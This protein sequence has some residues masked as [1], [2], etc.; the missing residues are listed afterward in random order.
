MD[1]FE[2]NKIAGAILGTLMLTMALSL[3]SGFVFAPKVAP[4][5]GYDLPAAP[6]EEAAAAP[7]EGAAPAAPL[8]VLLAKADVGKGEAS[9]KVC[10]ACHNFQKGG[11]AKVGPP[12][13]GVVGRNVAS[14]EGFD[15]SE[16]LKKKGG[17]WGFEEIN[18]FITN[19]KGYMPGTKMGYAGETNAEKRAD[20][21][22]YLHTLSDAPQPLP[23]P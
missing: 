17:A 9:A 14:I 5:P 2:F 22:D 1:S 18:A 20:I 15:Y 11:A 8:P 3:F 19:P 12:L 21:V 7:A 13:W 23:T 10:A 16:S 6:A 4:K